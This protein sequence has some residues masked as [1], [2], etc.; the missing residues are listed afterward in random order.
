MKRQNETKKRVLSNYRKKDP[1]NVTETF[2]KILEKF[3]FSNEFIKKLL[4]FYTCSEIMA[5]Q[6]IRGKFKP[7]EIVKLRK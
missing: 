1:V 3:G 6:V 5:G 4:M 2:N 7:K